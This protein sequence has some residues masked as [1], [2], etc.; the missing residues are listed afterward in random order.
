MLRTLILFVLFLSTFSLQAQRIFSA[1]N[2]NSIYDEQNPFVD[3]E[4]G[5]LYFTRSNDPANAGG[6]FDKGDIWYSLRSGNQWSSPINAQMLNN[7]ALNSVLGI[8]ASGDLLLYGHY[9]DK[10][11]VKTQG[12]AV[13]KYSN[14]QFT[15]PQNIDIPYFKNVSSI[16]GG[17]I[18]PNGEVLLFSL[19]SYDSKGTED[20][21]V[22]LKRGD[23]WTEPRNLGATINTRNQEF[24]PSI[25]STLDTLYF[26]S[27]GHGGSG[28]SDVFMSVR[29]GSSWTNWSTPRAL[30]AINSSGQERGF[31]KYAQYAT[32]TSTQNSDGYGDIKFYIE[33]EHDSLFDDVNP[34]NPLNVKLEEVDKELVVNNASFFTLY[35]QVKDQNTEDLIDAVLQITLEKE[36]DKRVVT[37]QP[38]K[39]YSISLPS[40]GVYTIKVTAEDYISYQEQLEV[41]SAELKLLEKDFALQKIEVGARVKLENV[42][43]KQSKA[44]IEKSSYD[45]LNL[46]VAL[47]RDNPS[48]KIRLEGHTDNRGNAKQNLKLSK[49]RVEEVKRFLIKRG[50]AKKRVSGKGYG[51]A[52]PIADN[53]DPNSRKLNRRVEFIILRQ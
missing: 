12:L 10:S 49:E 27:N 9:A 28:S 43:F 39:R 53:S 33:S 17:S 3:E 26:S 36:F 2:I 29:Q 44:T 42:L 40:A 20:I 7:S 6:K 15:T 22:S 38:G 18:S 34:E 48:M 52:K 35:G 30:K 16:F 47:L 24:D 8:N 51:G 31:K 32:F 19:E 5:I 1:D 41:F 37:D 25:N 13:S 46:V 4:N 11:P 21:Y 45:E 23:T 50:I 14:G